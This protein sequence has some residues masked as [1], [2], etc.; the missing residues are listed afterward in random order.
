MMALGSPR[1]EAGTDS[2]G[3]VGQTIESYVGSTA[4]CGMD[5]DLDV[6]NSEF[7]MKDSNMAADT[8]SASAEDLTCD[9][10][11]RSPSAAQLKEQTSGDHLSEMVCVAP[12]NMPPSAVGSSFCEVRV[13]NSAASC[14][15]SA[16]GISLE[17][18]PTGSVNNTSSQLLI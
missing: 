13:N 10:Y 1:T 12:S 17:T 5:L 16:N 3:H 11:S 8:L 7:S 18:G 14:K 9:G 6:G 2:A 15:S 4:N